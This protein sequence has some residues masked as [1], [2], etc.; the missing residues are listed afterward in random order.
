M[1]EEVQSEDFIYHTQIAANFK[2]IKP[3]EAAAAA[4]NLESPES[5]E[6]PA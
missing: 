2:Y 5:A 3:V 4:V 6:A 1:V